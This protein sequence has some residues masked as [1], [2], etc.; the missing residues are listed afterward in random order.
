[1]NQDIGILVVDDEQIVR[2]SLEGWFAEDGY[3]VETAASAQEA[4]QKLQTGTWHILLVDIKMPGMDGLE[5]QQRVKEIDENVVVIIMTAYASVETAVQALKEGAYDYITKPFDPDEL[6]HI[7]RNAIERRRLIW[8]NAL[9]RENLDERAGFSEI[10][11]TSKAILGVLEQVAQVASTDATVMILGESGTGKE[12]IAQA[13]HKQSRRRYMPTVTVNCG[14][15]AEGLLESELFG[16]ERGAFTGAQYRKKGKFE[17]ADG[18]T[19]FLDEVGDVSSKTQADLLRVLETKEFTRVGGTKPIKSDFRVISATNK[20]LQHLI[21]DGKF[22]LDLY[23]R[24]NAFTIALPPLRDR[25]EDVPLLAEHFRT[26]L[27]EQ[28][29]K[30]MEKV[31]DDALR[32]LA[33]YDWPGNVRELRHVI[34]HAIVIARSPTIT[35]DDIRLVGEE[36]SIPGDRRVQGAARPAANA[37]GSLADME[38]EH[39]HAVLADTGWNITQAAKA[40]D[41]DRVT[42]YNKIRKYGIQRPG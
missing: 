25:I 16:H 1:M 33:R 24:L 3:R 12:L 11:G 5:L 28:L 7:I 9:L 26:T 20:D 6:A 40:L 35:A 36:V 8:E 13:I 10:I 32:K 29:H 37:S 2:E 27:T 31:G 23:Y 18:G 41:I 21:R 4:L 17:L 34:E 22:R 14:A 30:P 42:L 19:I 39:I 38:K 15:M